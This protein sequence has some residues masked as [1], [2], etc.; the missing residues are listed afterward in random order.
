VQPEDVAIPVETRPG[1]VAQVDFGYVGRLYDPRARVM[2]KAWVFVMVLGYSRHM[3]ARIVFDQSSET[4]LRLHVGLGPVSPRTRSRLPLG[5]PRVSP[6][7][8]SS[9]GIQGASGWPRTCSTVSA[10]NPV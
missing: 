1:E 5:L 10:D 7:P 9:S 2:R 4:W 3:F 6:S 8:S